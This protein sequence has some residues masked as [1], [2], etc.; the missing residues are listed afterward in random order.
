MIILGGIKTGR[1]V[2]EARAPGPGAILAVSMKQLLPR[3]EA[4]GLH[5][6]SALSEAPEE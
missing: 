6:A 4:L 1:K 3:Q 5:Q 2:Q